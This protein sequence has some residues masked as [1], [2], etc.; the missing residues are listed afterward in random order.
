MRGATASGKARRRKRS[1]F[2]ST[3]PMRGATTYDSHTGDYTLFQSTHP[4]RG[5]TPGPVKRNGSQ[6]QFQS[7]HPMRGATRKSRQ[8]ERPAK[9]I[10]IHAPHA[11][12]DKLVLAV[13]SCDTI[14][15]HA[16]HAGCDAVLTVQHITNH[17]ISI[18]APH[19]GCD[20]RLIDANAL[21]RISIHAPHAGCDLRDSRR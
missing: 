2:Q 1:I 11:G 3:H 14:S 8:A 13:V 6:R 20:M 16:P 12:C 9:P 15:I 19:A 5:A 7:T 21:I 4:M 18:H 10:S 17:I